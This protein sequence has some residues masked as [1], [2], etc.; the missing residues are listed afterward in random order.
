MYSLLEFA[1][2]N[3]SIIFSLSAFQGEKGKYEPRM[4]LLVLTEFPWNIEA[5]CLRGAKCAEA[6]KYSPS[7]YSFTCEGVLGINHSVAATPCSEYWLLYEE[8]IAASGLRHKCA[9]EIPIDLG[10][11]LLRLA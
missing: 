2:E 7:M 6:P 10:T 4:P 5:C 1:L 3:F 11:S 8:E 9:S